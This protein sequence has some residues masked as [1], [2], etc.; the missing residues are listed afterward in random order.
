[1]TEPRGIELRHGCRVG[2]LPKPLRDRFVELEVADETVRWI[3][4]A[5]AEPQPRAV[6][7]LARA[8]QAAVG[9]YDANGLTGAYRMR[10][11]ATAQWSVLL[12]DE[13][14]AGLLDIG[15]GDGEVTATLAPLFEHVVTTELS[16]PMARRL[17]ERGYACHEVDLAHTALPVAKEGPVPCF[18][19]VALLNVLDRTLFP[20]TLLARAAAHVSGHGRLVV[21]VPVPVRP[22]VLT[23]PLAVT[24]EEALPARSVTFEDAASELAEWLLAPAGLVVERVARAPYLCR[25]DRRVPVTQLDD[26]IFVCRRP[27]AP[28]GLVL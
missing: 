16:A 28:G 4:R 10:I 2:R 21:A 15:A 3:E 9:P 20:R 18:D 8:V 14:H 19:V 26:A 23:G 13:R 1:M 27:V 7:M 6:S 11:L 5:R 22:V 24:P 25:G 17:R 12:G